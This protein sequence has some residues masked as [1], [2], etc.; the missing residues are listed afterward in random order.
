[1]GSKGIGSTATAAD[2]PPYLP[3]F[4]NERRAITLPSNVTSV[5]HWGMA[6]I[7]FGQGQGRSYAEVYLDTDY[8]NWVRGLDQP[9]AD[10]MRD[11]KNYVLAQ[12]QHVRDQNVQDRQARNR[13]AQ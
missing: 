10:A 4:K 11:F 6:E 1:M 12:D 9:K 13:Q 5:E 8:C 7:T 2:K 3:R